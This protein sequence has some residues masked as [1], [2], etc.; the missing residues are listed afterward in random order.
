[1]KAKIMK[2]LQTLARELGLSHQRATPS[3][4]PDPVSDYVDDIVNDSLQRMRA[5][6]R[7]MRAF[8]E[9]QDARMAEARQRLAAMDAQANQL[10]PE[11]KARREE[12]A[13]RTIERHQAGKCKSVSKDFLIAWQTYLAMLDALHGN[14]IVNQALGVNSYSR[15]RV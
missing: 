11:I 12:L 8:D 3:T 5:F 1:M 14:R 6:G 10:A 9:R 15:Y 13:A 7:E 4:Q 2:F